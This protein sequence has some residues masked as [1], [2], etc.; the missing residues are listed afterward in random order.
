MSSLDD[1][2]GDTPAVAE[3]QQRLQQWRAQCGNPSFRELAF[4][5]RKLERPQAH[6]TIQTKVTGT[7]VPDWPFVE[8]FVQACGRHAALETEPDLRPWR[9]AHTRMRG[10]EGTPPIGDPY[11]RL[12]AF[13]ED[14]T[15]WFHGRHDA[16]D[17]VLG[18]IRGPQAAVLVLGPSGAGKSSLVHAGVLPALRDG[19]LPGSDRWNRISVRPRQNLFAELDQV[20]LPTS[21]ASLPEAVG[22]RLA[23]QPAEGRLLL[24]IDQFEELL[25]PAIDPSHEQI[26]QEALA[27]LAE[28]ARLPRAILILAMRD[29]FYPHLSAQA[30]DLRAGLTLVDLPATLTVA[31]LNDIIRGPAKTAGLTWDPRLPELVVNDLLADYA[32]WRVHTTDNVHAGRQVPV[33]VL[34]LLELTLYQ[35]WARRSGTRLIHDGYRQTG[36]IRGAVTSWCAA[37]LDELPAADKDCAR[38]ILTALVRPADPDLAVPAVRQQV[39]IDTLRQLVTLDPAEPTTANLVDRVLATL[40][41][42]RVI[43]TSTLL[44]I[45]DDELQQAQDHRVPVAELAHD[46]LIR[47]WPQLLAW[48]DADHRF[49][50]WL[51]RT[52]ER[53]RRWRQHP[54][55]GDLLH[56]T[57]LTEGFDW[58][59]RRAL[60]RELATFLQASR[61]QQQMRTRRARRLNVILAGLLVVALTAAG[62]ATWFSVTTAAAKSKSRTV[63]AATDNLAGV[64]LLSRLMDT[65]LADY[66]A[67]LLTGTEEDKQ[68]TEQ[69]GAAFLQQLEALRNT[70]TDS[71]LLGLLDRISIAETA[72]AAAIGSAMTVRSEIRDVA[73]APQLN[74]AQVKPLRQLLQSLLADLVS[75][76]RADV[77]SAW[78][79]SSGQIALAIWVALAVGVSTAIGMIVVAWRLSRDLRREL[80]SRAS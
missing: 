32:P 7:T 36:G 31:Q 66:R 38:Q 24:V 9:E 27:Q 56:G 2:G 42:Q 12:D 20:G 45:R 21:G 10:A 78:A 8:T 51:H 40:T 52:G 18:A 58:A 74:T 17:Q 70:V 22:R 60:P 1:P 77:E 28:V 53:H 72:Y 30:P 37:A 61:H 15:V 73:E 67:Y 49:Q 3:L 43:T 19:A 11:R 68:S 46:T 34:P 48:V 44:E 71:A 16:V 39:P 41:E 33:T 76:A 75:R 26:R 64:E 35:V 5:F 59:G 47:D 63:A 29:D 25:T 23:G 13:G 14:D 4:L 6:T 80:E 69:D 50:R 55:D 57:D 65:R 54:A 79:D 62:A